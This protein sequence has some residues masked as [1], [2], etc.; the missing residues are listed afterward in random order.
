MHKAIYCKMIKMSSVTFIPLLDS[1]PM[2]FLNGKWRPF[3]WV[4]IVLQS[5]SEF[6]QVSS[7]SFIV[8][9]VTTKL[10]LVQ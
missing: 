10:L 1:L 9:V 2:T 7:M 3:Y 8:K 4:E 5:S 6:F